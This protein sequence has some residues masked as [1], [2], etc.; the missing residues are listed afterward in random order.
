MVDTERQHSPS[1]CHCVVCGRGRQHM[2]AG[3]GNTGLGGPSAWSPQRGYPAPAH[4]P[5]GTQRLGPGH[6]ARAGSGDAAA[7]GSQRHPTAPAGRGEK[8]GRERGGENGEE[9]ISGGERMFLT[10]SKHTPA[11]WEQAGQA[12]GQSGEQPLPPAETP[13]R[14]PAASLPGNWELLTP[15][16]RAS[17]PGGTGDAALLPGAS[18]Q[19]LLGRAVAGHGASRAGSGPP[20]PR[21]GQG[22]G[23]RL[24]AGG[25]AASLTGGA[26]GALPVAPALCAPCGSISRSGLWMGKGRWEPGGSGAGTLPQSTRHR[27][28]AHPPARCTPAR[29][30]GT[31]WRGHV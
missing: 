8:P 31:A 23:S 22:W 19:H 21:E 28:P 18:T 11:G 13:S 1:C 7:T 14:P 25:V 24:G 27:E 4:D 12:G 2:P 15:T 5:P 29:A 26:V 30:A 10:I 17:H 3:T 16:Q 9:E 20:V 6:T